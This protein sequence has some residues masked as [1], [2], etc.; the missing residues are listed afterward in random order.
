METSLL[1]L[2]DTGISECFTCLASHFYFLFWIPLR[3]WKQLGKEISEGQEMGST[4]EARGLV[5][6]DFPLIGD[7][8]FAQ[9]TGSS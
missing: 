2:H 7:G 9:W 4:G 3:L 1:C 5:T 8:H 6:E